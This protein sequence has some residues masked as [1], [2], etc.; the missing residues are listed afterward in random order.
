MRQRALDN[1]V[2]D[3][4]TTLWIMIGATLCLVSG[5]VIRALFAERRREH[6]QKNA[7]QT[8]SKKDPAGT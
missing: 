3:K 8:E 2:L 1:Y 6:E 7:S 5:I 4:T